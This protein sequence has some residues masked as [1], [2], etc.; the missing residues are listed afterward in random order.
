MTSLQNNATKSSSNQAVRENRGLAKDRWLNRLLQTADSQTNECTLLSQMIEVSEGN[1]DEINPI[2]A[3]TVGLPNREVKQ[4]KIRVEI[5]RDEI[6]R[7]K[8]KRTKVRFNNLTDMY[9]TTT[10]GFPNATCLLTY[11]MVVVNSNLDEMEKRQL[12]LVG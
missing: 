6:E 10:T 8:D 5:P 11:I 7:I 4:E 12:T 3:R 1:I 2:V 9:V